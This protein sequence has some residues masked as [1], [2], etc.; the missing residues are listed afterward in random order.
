MTKKK[1][2]IVEWAMH[3]RQIVIMVACCLVAFGVYGLADMNKNEFPDFTV[4]QGVVVAVYPGVSAQDIEEQLTKPLENYIFSYKEVK[5]EKTKSYS[6][7][8]M[9]IIQIELNDDV[10]GTDKD[11]FWSKFKHGINTFKAQLPSGVLAL[12]VQDDFGDT[13]ALLITMESKDKT[14][15]EL[16]DYMDD[17]KDR[18]R[19]IESIGRMNVLGM[20]KEQISIYLDS[21]KMSHYGI[22]TNTIAA[23]LFAKGFVTTAGTQKGNGYD[24]PIQVERSLNVVGDVEQLVVYSDPSGNVV[25]LKDVAKIRREYPQ[26]SSYVT[27]NGQKCLVLSVEMKKGRSITAMGADIEKVMDEFKSTLPS[28]V[29]IFTITDQTKVVNDSV[30][31]FLRELLIA[32]A[33]VVIVIMLF[34]P[35]RVA[36]V[37]A[38]TIPISIFISLGLFY[39]FGIEL[40]TV[41]LAALIVTL[42]MIVDN[43]IV[44]IDSYMEMLAEGKSRWTASISSATHFFKSIFSATLAISITFF[45]FLLT[46]K[47]MYHDFLLYFP[48]S[49]TI[50]LLISLLVAELIVPFLQFYFIRKPVG[51]GG[52]KKFSFLDLVQR[53]YDWLIG[54]CFAHPYITVSVGVASIVI[55]SVMVSQLPQKMMPTAERNQFAVE[56]YLPDGTSLKRTAAVADSLEHILRKDSRVVSVASFKGTSSPRFHAAYAPQFGGSNYTQFIVNTKSNHD[57]ETLLKDY[58]M[59]YATHFPNAYVRF[60][61]L[62]YS[63]DANPV[64]LRLTGDDWQQ[65]K[66]V[67]DSVTRLWRNNPYLMLVRNDVN[68][69]LLT[70]DVV[71]DETK[72]GRM[73]V[74]NA[75]VEATLA[76]RY[77]SSGI[78]LGTIWD[79]DYNYGVCLKGTNADSSAIRDVA[80]ELIPVSGGL[81]VVPLRQIADIKPVWADG[82]IAHRN[83]LRTITVM[84]DVVNDKNVMELTTELQKNFDT[85]RLPSGVTAEWGGEYAESQESLPQILSALAVAVVIIFFILVWHFHRINTAVLLLVSLAMTI[86]GTS[87]GVLI[88]GVTFGMTCFLG[89]ISLM[90]ILVRNAIIMYDYA[91]ELREKE[92][93]TAHEAIFLSAK[94]RMRPIFLTSAAASMGVIPMILGGSG[95][96]MPMGAVIC[97]GTLVTMLLILTVLPVAYWLLMSGSTKRREAGLKLEN[98]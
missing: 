96:W 72:A 22:G 8:G 79:G 52:K 60:K 14:Y 28:D 69:P 17:L 44:I 36:L 30:V 3:Y 33:A 57:T 86:F 21:D 7:N 55:G 92:K 56:I 66:S 24:S 54:R 95:L 16:N 88:S 64:E 38:S 89:I 18:L 75:M 32:I 46:T 2:N 97:Y 12:M 83:G 19:R 9:A 26:P 4:R 87:L 74:T 31:N 51:T 47:G 39:A 82:Q 70:T 85:S 78:S 43:S 35:M 63:Q 61:Q 94:R 10:S 13:S 59:K 23:S 84:A 65:L 98:E 73:G 5:K 50:V 41:T 67:A 15:R 81:S 1:R 76:T 71:L 62:S 45:P 42:G 25:R 80:D 77:N 90:G 91:E 48:W 53:Y 68:E 27:N 40:N 49:I 93:L 11:N 34:L 6:R 20:Q 29:T 58:R 37:A